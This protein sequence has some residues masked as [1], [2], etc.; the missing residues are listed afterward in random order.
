MI[1]VMK[2]HAPEAA[3]EAVISF[4]VTFDFDVHRSSGHERTI[5]GVVGDVTRDD[6]GV[7][8]E[9]EGVAEVVRVSDPYRLASR[10]PHGRTS[11]YSG[12]FGKLG[13]QHAPWIAVEPVGGAD[14]A[15][16]A[17][18]LAGTT[19]TGKGFDAAIARSNAAPDQ[20]AGGLSRLALDDRRPEARLLFVERASGTRLDTWMQVAEGFL[21]RKA[22]VVL[23]EAGDELSNG[24]RAFDVVSLARA[25]DRT[26]LPI[27]VD[28]PR[29]AGNARH[30]AAVATAALA[31]GADGV[32]LRV[33]TG[34]PD[35]PPRVP[36]AL[37]LE[38]AAR[39][40]ERLRALSA[41]IR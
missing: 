12:S 25:R 16:T 28:V 22:N 33:R 40:A 8:S 29:I 19:L 5:L 6:V 39:L 41:V 38:E 31:S 10:E 11:E 35:D 2:P 24:A 17:S 36:A 21:E 13:G 20:K 1:I 34:R 15:S 32:I 14:R 30:S 18:F 23:L 9:F 7:V 3:I 26:H 37:S 27:V 4:L